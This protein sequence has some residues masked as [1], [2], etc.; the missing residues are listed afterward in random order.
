LGAEGSSC[1]LDVLYGELAIIKFQID[2]KNILKKFSAVNFFQF[3]I[4]ETLDPDTGTDWYS[5][6]SKMPDPDPDPVP[7]TMNPDPKHCQEQK[8]KV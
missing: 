5:G 4:I 2:F 3:L 1:S 7:E 8:G 6:H